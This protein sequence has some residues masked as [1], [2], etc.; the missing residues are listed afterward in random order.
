MGPAQSA[1]VARYGASAISFGTQFLLWGGG[2]DRLGNGT[3]TGAIYDLSTG[4]WSQISAANA[5]SARRQHTAVWTGSKMLVWG[6]SGNLG[7]VANG[8]AYSP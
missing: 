3:Q 6:G 2:I 5:P 7:W 1:P 4:Q 8:A